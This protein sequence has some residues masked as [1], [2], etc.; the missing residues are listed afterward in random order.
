MRPILAGLAAT[1]LF[2]AC[3]TRNGPPHAAQLAAEL[4]VRDLA[5]SRAFYEQLGFRPAHVEKNFVELQWIDGHKLFL[6]ESKARERAASKPVVNL[7]IGVADVDA[8]WARARAMNAKVITPI[9]DRFYG[10]RDFLI[11]DPDGFGLRFAGLLRGG[12]W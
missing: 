9:G 4:S 2:T 1:C 7:R 5:A 12:H 8:S 3:A 11:A 6:S 10:E